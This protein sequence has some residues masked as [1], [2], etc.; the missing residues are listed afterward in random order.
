MHKIIT[1]VYNVISYH[2]H[3]MLYI[4]VEAFF[5]FR[6]GKYQNMINIIKQGEFY[7]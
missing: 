6:D 4:N 1:D 2:V 7:L 3:F 5:P